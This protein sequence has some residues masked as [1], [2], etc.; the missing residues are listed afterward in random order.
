VSDTYK[1]AI[2]I[3]LTNNVS[4]ILAII[5]KDMVGLS[6]GA[7]KDVESGILGWG[8]VMAVVAGAAGIDLMV[9]GF[10]RIVKAG[11]EVNHQIELMKLAGMSMGEINDSVF[12]A[13]KTSGVVLTTNLSGNLAHIRELRYAFGDVGVAMEHLSEISKANSILNAVKGGGHDQVWELVKGLEQKGETFDPAQFSSYVNTM[14]KGRFSR[15]TLSDVP[16]QLPL[17]PMRLLAVRLRA[18]AG[19]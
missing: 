8:R 12:Q 11:G 7:I 18:D 2:A 4:P 15:Q 14:T 6:K 13:M 19:A 3:G 17:A 10:A 5:A 1:I 16:L 9:S